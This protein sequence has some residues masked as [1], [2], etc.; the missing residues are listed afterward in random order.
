[1]CTKSLT[2]RRVSL[3]T[4]KHRF[5]DSFHRLFVWSGYRKLED[6]EN[7]LLQDAVLHFFPLIVYC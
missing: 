6:G 4:M 3:K 1:M 2:V 5:G 7:V